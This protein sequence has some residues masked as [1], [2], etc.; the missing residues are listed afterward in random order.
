M[1]SA[2]ILAVTLVPVLMGLLI[3]GKIPPEQSNPV[4][5]WLTNLYRPALDWTMQRPKTVLMIAALLFATT[6]WPPMRPCG[7]FMPTMDAG[8]L[9]YMP[10][11]LPVLSAAKAS[12]L[13][14]QHEHGR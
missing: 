5:R 4:N 2:A 8:D 1:A 7:E 11:A 3:R 6:A 14:Q 13:L 10:S 12:Q 9:L